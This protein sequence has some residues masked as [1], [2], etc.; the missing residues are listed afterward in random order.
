MTQT[1]E[2]PVRDAAAVRV[3]PPLVPLGTILA[4]IGLGKLWPIDLGLASWA[5]RLTLIGV[6]IL[7]IAVVVWVWAL[8]VM[9]RSGQD[10]H[11]GKPTPRILDHGPY[12]FSRNPIYLQMVLVC[13]GFAV[14]QMNPW[15]LLLTPVAAWLLQKLVI[16]PEEDYL[17]RKFGD[18]YLDYKRRVR[19]WI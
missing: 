2:E 4:G 10:P 7:L 5:P 6:T 18:A 16:V 1:Q 12:R 14:R 19:R 11:T 15:L 9:G 17:E 3:F 13:L 8:V